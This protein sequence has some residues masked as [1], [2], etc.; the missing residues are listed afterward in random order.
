MVLVP[1]DK[2]E[3][4]MS[5]PHGK[6]STFTCLDVDLD[7]ISAF[8]LVFSEA[9]AGDIRLH[10]NRDGDSLSS[11]IDGRGNSPKPNA[12]FGYGTRHEPHQLRRH[13]TGLDRLFRR[14]DV[15]LS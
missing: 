1:E 12:V 2:I 6:P 4:V 11:Q 8:T 13:N 14:G 5:G 9:E 10:H 15:S 3:C 7:P